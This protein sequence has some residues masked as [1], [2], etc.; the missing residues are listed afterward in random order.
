MLL[1][2]R[3]WDNVFKHV[4][5]IKDCKCLNMGSSAAHPRRVPV[6]SLMS[7]STYHSFLLWSLEVH[8]SWLL[9]ALLPLW[10][11]PACCVESA[12]W[13]SVPD[14]PVRLRVRFKAHTSNSPPTSTCSHL[15]GSVVNDDNL[16][17]RETLKSLNFGVKYSVKSYL[18]LLI[19]F[20][21]V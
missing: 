14:L 4:V 15:F 10:L 11:E 19:F 12:V 13:E 3:K 20:A 21:D 5:F 1:K 7:W 6:L 16:F 8:E 17:S 2:N 18:I 9:E